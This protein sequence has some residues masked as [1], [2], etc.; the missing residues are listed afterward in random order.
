[1]PE[2]LYRSRPGG[3]DIR[4][5]SQT[6]A[7][8]VADSVWLSE[9]LSNAY[10]VVTRDGRVVV[11]T[12]MG[13]EGP[14][15]RRLFDAV[16]AGPVRYIFLTQSHVDHVGGV[17]VFRE[18]GTEIVAQANNAFCQADDAR[19]HPF[20]VAH[21][22][23]FFPTAVD[24]AEKN[25]HVQARPTPTITFA[26]RH[27]ITLGGVRFELI[28]TPGG[29][30]VDSMVVW[31]PE[32][33]IALVGNVFS[34]LFGHFPNLVTLRGDRYRFALPFVDA[35]DRVL[36]LEPELLLTGHFAPIRGGDLI[37]RELERVRD[38]VKYVHDAT[39]AGMNAGRDLL[40]LMRDIEL[41][42][43]LEVG[44]GYGCVAWSVRA[45]WEGYAGWFHQRS[46]TELY[47][48]PVSDVYP[49]V[50]ELAG[51]ADVVAARARARLD[52]GGAVAAIH[53]AE[54]ALATEPGSRAALEVYRAAHERL[55]AER[56][57]INFWETG[58]LR[59]QIART[60][61]ALGG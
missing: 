44:Q 20:R 12:G 17:A 55:L 29:E 15:H 28:A 23:P 36:A 2:P 4:P 46:T 5:A 9:G 48:V 7:T 13:F 60:S 47:P 49:D 25:L 22:A 8:Q 1:M 61:A 18:A 11:N 35:V 43:E 21:S 56:G 16:D 37:R 58:W 26:D 45:I 34:A 59:H 51:G 40:S 27:E 24:R 19:L 3:F 30:T 33:R 38:A 52:A 10:L 53:L 14:L 42:A 50:V 31:L 54:M 32:Q 41:P 6:A 39:V 57:A